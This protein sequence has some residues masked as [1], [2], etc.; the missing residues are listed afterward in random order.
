MA[1]VSTFEQVDEG[2]LVD[3]VAPENLDQVLE[4]LASGS[5]T[6]E[7]L[8]ETTT[9]T[10][11]DNDE[12]L[13]DD[14]ELDL[15]A[16]ESDKAADPVRLYMREMGR[17]PLLNKEQEVAIAKRI[18]W[19]LQRAQKGITRS[20]IAIEELLKI[21][22]ELQA[23]ALPIRDVVSF[24]D[25]MDAEE[26]ELDDKA[27]EYLAWTLEGIEN[28]RKLF[29]RA[30]KE[31][32]NFQ[33]EQKRTRGKASKKLLRL[34]RKLAGT[35]LEIAKEIRGLRLKEE[36]RQRLI[37]AIEAVHKEVRVHEREIQ[38]C[39][40]RASAP[41]VKAAEA[42]QLKKQISAGKRRLKEI[43]T[44][45]HFSAVEIKRSWQMISAGEAQAA[46]AKHELTE[47]NL[48]LVVSIAKKYQNRGLQFLDLIQ[49]GNLGLMK[50]VE[51]FDWRRGYK[52]STYATWWIRQAI[53]RAIADQ[54]R[55]IRVPVHM[56]EV[57]NKVK[58]VTRELVVELGREP[59]TEEIAKRMQ[60]TADKVSKALNLIQ[61]PIS[62]EAPIGE[63]G[64]AQVG[65][66][67]EDQSTVSPAERVISSNARDVAGDVLQTLSPREEKVIRLRFGLDADGRERTLEEVGEDFNVTRER[68]RQIE[69]KALRK[70]RHP[71]RARV[72]KTLL[73]VK[74]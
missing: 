24:S 8:I 66:F 46:Q 5:E 49:E 39:S 31:L 28:I 41:R 53:T 42:E 38:R 22:Q 47:A 63:A 62:L 68:I 64:E 27:P 34:R 74:A 56:V 1:L 20:P 65:D 14:H 57:I 17:V 25:Q 4:Q 40:E 32:T 51:K 18:E 2:V 11:S 23:G 10:S 72:L 26:Q 44:L 54:S 29:R 12:E 6:E 69:V 70:L 73:E 45:H 30:L 61:H 59:S 7:S 52:F 43:E 71:S 58:K 67:I 16:G 33:D 36:V 19:G 48:R 21:S 35:R 13:G 50:G 15:S 9:E 3:S 37:N 55:T 60:S